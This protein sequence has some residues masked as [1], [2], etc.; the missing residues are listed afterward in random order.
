MINKTADQRINTPADQAI[1]STKDQA[2]MTV[3]P[4]VATMPANSRTDAVLF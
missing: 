1:K 3:R 2:R 4:N